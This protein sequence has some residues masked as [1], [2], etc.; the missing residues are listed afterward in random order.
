MINLCESNRIFN[1]KLTFFDMKSIN[2]HFWIVKVL[3]MIN[4]CLITVLNRMYRLKHRIGIF[5]V[6]LQKKFLKK[7]VIENKLSLSDRRDKSMHYP[8]SPKV[9]TYRDLN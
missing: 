5:S 2:Y 1:R 8:E 9:N 3:K 4:N 7:F 6:D